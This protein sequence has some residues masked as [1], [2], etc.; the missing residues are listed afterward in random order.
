MLGM[1]KVN[2]NS[3][4]HADA[5]L[6]KRDLDGEVPEIFC[7]C[8]NRSGGKTTDFSR[9]IIDRWLSKEYREVVIL[10][11]FVNEIPGTKDAFFNKELLEHFYT[12]EF[13][14]SLN[15][16]EV[17]TA[18]GAFKEIKIGYRTFG[19]VVALNSADKV[20]KYSNLFSKVDCIF[21]DEFMPETGMYCQEE[22]AK[23]KSIHVSIARS[24]GSQSRYVPI[25]MASNLVSLLNPYFI[26]WKVSS[27]ISTSTRFLRGHGIVIEQNFNKAAAKAQSE[28][29]FLRAFEEDD[30][31]TKQGVYL[32]DNLNL[33]GKIK[34][35]KEY[36]FTMVYNKKNYGVYQTDE[37]LVYISSVAD[38]TC[39][40]KI[41]SV[42]AD[43]CEG[44]F[45]KTSFRDLYSTVLTAFNMGLMRFEN[46]EAKDAAFAFLAYT[47]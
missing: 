31:Y 26:A 41:A 32:M 24:Y 18:N 38:S 12:E 37:Q 29:K 44:V 16:K 4:Y 2:P 9:K 10:K 20:K 22:I 15:I 7:V 1:A 42:P 45:Y 8:G 6:N 11:R 14:N 19:Y 33:V 25:F 30:Y 3:F 23:F 47:I 17:N 39:R 35:K 28:S 13:I 21:F 27:R 46:Q 34:S 43:V 5:L 36:F 40:V